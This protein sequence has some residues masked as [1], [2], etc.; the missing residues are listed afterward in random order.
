MLSQFLKYYERFKKEKR[1]Q[2]YLQKEILDLERE[3]T[4]L[5]QLK[6]S[7]G[8]EESSAK[9]KALIW[10]TTSSPS[11]VVREKKVPG[12][13][14]FSGGFTLH[15]GRTASENDEL[16]R[17]LIRGNDLWLHARDYPGSYVF[18]KAVKGKTVPLEVLIDAGNLALYYSKGRSAGKGNLY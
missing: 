17:K 6:A 16:L 11:A 15:V 13:T 12:L 8:Q 10:K 3:I 18:I 14:F 1:T 5:E 9:L 4:R 2:E 7:L